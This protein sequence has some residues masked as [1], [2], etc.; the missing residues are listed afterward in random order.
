[1]RVRQRNAPTKSRFHAFTL[2][3]TAL[4]QYPYPV[5]P[6]L[7]GTVKPPGLLSPKQ[8]PAT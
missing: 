7:S 6:V 1:M 4:R 8:L 3:R 5:E 2:S